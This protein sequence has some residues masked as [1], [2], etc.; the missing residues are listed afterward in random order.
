MS[1]EHYKSSP[2]IIAAFIILIIVIIG[3]IIYYLL[4]SKNTKKSQPE[5]ITITD[6]LIM[7][8]TPTPN[9]SVSTDSKT[10]DWKTYKIN[11]L[12]ISFKYPKE[13]GEA[14]LQTGAVSANVGAGKYGK[15]IF[16]N[17]PPKKEN[18]YQYSNPTAGYASTVLF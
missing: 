17:P 6:N 1:K 18:N 3:F 8:S 15:I 9:P 7:T 5:V 14:T 4:A 16:S 11:D 10:K 2:I 13:W 12:G